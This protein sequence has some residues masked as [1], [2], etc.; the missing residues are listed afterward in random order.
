MRKYAI[1]VAGGAGIRMGHDIPKQFI[2][3]GGMPILMHT[4]NAFHAT[5]SSIHIIVVLPADQI[6]YWQSLCDHYQF[7]APH[8]IAEGG[9]TRF[10]SVKNG[11]SLVPNEALV[12]IHDGVRPFV[13]A[14]TIEAAYTKA[15]E[16]GSAVVYVPAKESLRVIE[17]AGESKAVD[18]SKYAVIQTPQ[19]FKSS[20]IKAAFAQEESTAFTDDASVLEAFGG[21]I[22]LIEGNY[23][24]IKITTKEDLLIAEAFL[25]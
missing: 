14:E 1:I 21:Q 23:K 10:Q 8:D 25:K 11:L 16:V 7:D 19:T 5:D 9:N 15:N 6:K 22:H 24:N 2:A 20:L 4:L 3:V 18:R 13:D 17:D 12:A